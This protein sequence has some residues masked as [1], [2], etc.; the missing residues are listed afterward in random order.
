MKCINKNKKIK[1]TP[2]HETLNEKNH[3]TITIEYKNF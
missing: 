2:R 3:L 1:K